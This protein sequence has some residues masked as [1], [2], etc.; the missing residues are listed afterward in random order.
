MMVLHK[1]NSVPERNC[2]DFIQL[3]S[4]FL[5]CRQKVNKDRYSGSAERLLRLVILWVIQG[6]ILRDGTA[7]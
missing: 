7:M 6:E 5:W 2:P 1:N 3:W 4:R